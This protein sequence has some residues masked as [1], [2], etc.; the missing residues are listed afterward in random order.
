M[1]TKYNISKGKRIEAPVV[2]HTLTWDSIVK[3]LSKHRIGKTKE[4]NGY[5][6]GGVFNNDYRNKTNLLS[7]CLLTLDV[8]SYEGPLDDLELDLDLAFGHLSYIVYSTWSSGGGNGL[9][10]RLVF[11]LDKD[12]DGEQYKKLC[13]HFAKKYDW[14]KFDTSGFKAES[15]MYMPSCPEDKLSDAFVFINK[16]V[17]VSCDLNLEDD[18]LEDDDWED[19]DFLNIVNSQPL[20]MADEEIDHYL[21]VYPADSLEYDQWFDVGVALN[22]QYMGSEK[23]LEK[24]INWT[25]DFTKYNKEQIEYK[26][27]T[28]GKDKRDKP[29]TFATII[30]RVTDNSEHIE[31]VLLE[32]IKDELEIDKSFDEKSYDTLRKK[33]QKTPLHVVSKTKREMIAHEI[34]EKWGKFFSITKTSIKGEI[35]PKK[36]LLGSNGSN[37][38]LEQGGLLGTYN[39]APDWL[40]D[41]WVYVEVE[42]KFANIC[43]NYSINKDAFNAKFDRMEDC[44]ILEKTASQMALTVYNMPTVVDRM[45]WPKAGSIYEYDGKRMLNS[46]VPSG[47]CSGIVDDSGF[48]DADGQ[49][50]VD[51]FLAHVKF[52]LSNER[53]Q[54]ILLDWMT[55]VIQNPGERINWAL[56]LQGTQG[57]GKSYYANVLQWILGSNVKILDPAALVGRFTSWASGSILNVVEEIRISGENRWQI[58]DRLKSYIAN[59]TIQIEEKGRDHRT[60]PNFTSYLFLTNHQDAI[61]LSNEDRRYCVLYGDIQSKDDLHQKLN[62]A[63]ASELYFSTLFDESKRRSDALAVFFMS[64]PI[65]EG[66]RAKGRA[67]YTEARDRMIDYAT[68]DVTESVVDLITKYQCNLINEV[69]VDI[70]LLKH[71]IDSEFEVGGVGLPATNALKKILLELGY[72]KVKNRLNKK[73]SL[74]KHTVWYKHPFTEEMAKDRFKEYHENDD[75]YPF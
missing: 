75:V 61:P 72:E 73:G 7:R 17:A 49:T 37:G 50:V 67:P 31:K 43:L 26:Y 53:E 65:S 19:D 35:M 13:H 74:N 69:V 15:A 8:D 44:S 30:K 58:L 39:N 18:D 36:K 51:L 25:T 32:G 71:K 46:Y 2:R 6:V 14:I 55:H 56:L 68:N 40:K 52:T 16:G 63:E 64:R 33:L 29:L 27:N 3:S 5:F 28:I 48:I 4:E 41:K 62:G 22:H 21:E 9:R 34:Y 70:T 47:A 66:F 10:F 38:E 12:I 23:G 57:T 54:E 42:A 24:W 20:D 1:Q 60:V 11:P 45:Y 59:D